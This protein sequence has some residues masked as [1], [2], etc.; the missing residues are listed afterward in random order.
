MVTLTINGMPVTVEENTTILHAA[1]KLGIKIPSLCHFELDCFSM[2]HRMGSCRVCVVEVEGRRNL[3]PACCTP[4]VEGMV[5]N[6][7]SIR[8]INAR[9]TVVDLILSDHP[10]DCLT[11]PVNGNCELQALAG[12]LKMTKIAYEGEMSSYPMDVSSRSIVRNLD[13]CIMCRR[14]ETACNDMQTVG[15]LSGVGRGFEVVVAPTFEKPLS[16][17]ICVFCGQCVQACPVGALTTCIGVDEVWGVLNDPKKTVIVQTA[18]AVR[19]AL[20]EG[21]GMEPG[22]ISTGKMITALR[23]LGF[24][25]V[26]DTDFAADL[27]IMEET[28]EFIERVKSGE[29]LPIL[30]SCCPAW[31][32]FFEHQFPDLINIPSSA[33]SPQQMFGAIAKTYYAKKIGVDP[34]DLVVVSIMPC[35][36]K[37]YEADREEFGRDG[38]RDVDIVL[39]TRELVYML[40]EAGIVFDQ[41]EE[42][43]YDDPLGESTGAGVI[44][45][46][47]GGVLEAALRTAADWLTG[48]DLAKVDFK[49]VRGMQ[50]IKEA[51]VKVGDLEVRAAVSS[52]L[53]NARKLL[54]SIRAGTSSYHIIEIMACPGGCINGGGQPFIGGDTRILEK[55]MKAIYK[56]DTGLPLRKSHQNPS[57]QTLY[58][59]FLGEPGSHL[60]HELLHTGYTKRADE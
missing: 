12:D 8:A 47:S 58:K 33:K 17:T 14:C 4:V 53:G 7:N 25:A 16:E 60:A 39:S 23:R 3:A 36:S 6:T 11:C 26:F 29:N 1:A 28:T 59:E 9:R 37:K 57:I 46:A 19:V 20:G 50:G 48:E 54:E 41:L 35:L 5:V 43:Q 24:K 30:T 18:P 56:A 51:T 22:T 44:F 21:F 55:R 40:E 32:K 45:G 2:E 31:V 27:T 49:A 42:G 15:V 13:K 52:G 34:K 38:Y 10:K